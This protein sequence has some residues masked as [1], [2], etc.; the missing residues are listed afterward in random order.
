MLLA[1]QFTD[2][3]SVGDDLLTGSSFAMNQVGVKSEMSY[4]GS[5]LTFAYTRNSRGAD[6]QSPWSSYPGY[7]GVQVTDFNR[8]GENAFI[9]K[10]SYDFKRLG[11]DGTTAYGLF[12]HGWGKVDPSTKDPVPDENEFNLD[13]QWRPQWDFFKGLWLRTRYGVVR[14]YE[15]PSKYTHDFRVIINYDFPLL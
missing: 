8:A 12:V 10:V 5:I 6:L 9:A 11:L 15:G 13:V 14:Q 2:Q 3:R 7:T 1:M 4:G